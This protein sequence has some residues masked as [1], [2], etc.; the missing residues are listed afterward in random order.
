MIRIYLTGMLQYAS[1]YYREYLFFPGI[2]NIYAKRKE[3]C[4][5]YTQE[6]SFL[7][8]VGYEA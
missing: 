6:H 1:R 2:I 5:C 4:F 7:M 3:L 8:E